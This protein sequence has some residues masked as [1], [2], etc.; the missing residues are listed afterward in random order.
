MIT[1]NFS[2][3]YEGLPIN[4]SVTL[5]GHDITESVESLGELSVSSDYPCDWRI[6]DW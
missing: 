2:D 5:G 1:Q 4:M 3:A 6:P